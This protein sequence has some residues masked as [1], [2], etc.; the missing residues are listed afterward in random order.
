[1]TAGQFYNYDSNSFPFQPP[2]KDSEPHRREILNSFFDVVTTT[3]SVDWATNLINS[4]GRG[5]ICTVN[6]AILMMMRS[7]PRLQKF[8]DNAAL[9]VADGQPI[10]WASRLLCRPLPE[11]VS[12]VDLIDEIA[13]KSA[14]G[15][16]KIYL[17][18]AKSK[19]IEAAVAKLRKKYPGVNICG[20]SNGYF[21]KEEIPQ[22]VATIRESGAHV[23][24][25]GMGVPL[26]EF[27]L[28]DN[29]P[30]LGVNLAVG[31]GGSFE[32]FAGTK[33]RAPIWM[34]NTGLEWFYRLLQEPRRLWKRYFITNGQFI[35]QLFKAMIFRG[36]R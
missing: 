9:I 17:L 27:F 36:V 12:G 28:D 6:V 16:F 35:Y 23:L 32:I 24:F 33:K 15:D 1:M 31:V 5:Y 22:R 11:R 30:Q 8:V 34:Q 14:D 3:Q 19:V 18:G 4:G 13:K 26:Q 10:V 7:N 20:Y 2:K 21:S 29:W 25:I